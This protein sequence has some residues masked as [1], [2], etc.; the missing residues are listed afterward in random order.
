M[1]YPIIEGA[2]LSD[3]LDQ[4]HA[5]AATEAGLVIPEHL[6]VLAARLTR[7]EL[8]PVV[9][10]G[11]GSS[12]HALHS[13]H[14]ALVQRGFATIMVETSEL[15]FDLSPLLR[16]GTLLVIV[17]QSGASIEIVRLLDM[18]PSGVEII[19]VTNT[20][21]SP[22]ACRATVPLLTRAGSEHTVSCKTYLA[23]LLALSWLSGILCGDDPTLLRTELSQAA[24]TAELYLRGWRKHIESL[25]P[26]LDGARSLFLTGRGASLAATGVGGLIIKESAHFHAEGMSSA[27]FRHGPFE[28]LDSTT[29]VAVFLGDARTMALNKRLCL[30][31]IKAG[32]RAAEIGFGEGGGPFLLPRAPDRLRPILEM[33]PVEMISFALAALG[34]REAGK[35]ERASKITTI[36]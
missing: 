3:V 9:L 18:I 19:A 26:I 15:L 36:E 4:P 35:F 33:L 20:L 24:P 13:V 27:A 30:D 23:S 7:G 21:G 5:L 29:F 28:M 32:G 11:M 25:I 17:S 10:T 16:P 34:G 22:L 8:G 14:G 12:F 2:Y 6:D 31:V 1:N